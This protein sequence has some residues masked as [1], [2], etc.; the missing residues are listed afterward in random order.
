L[1]SSTATIMGPLTNHMN[2]NY[3]INQSDEFELSC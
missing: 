1:T 3:P 2:L